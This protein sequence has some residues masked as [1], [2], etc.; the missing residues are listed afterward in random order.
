MVSLDIASWNTDSSK[1]D[2]NASAARFNAISLIGWNGK[3]NVGDDAMTAVMINYIL[4]NLQPQATFKLLA[5]DGC[6]A[7]YTANSGS[8]K[9]F[10][11]YNRF[12]QIPYLRRW[13]NPLLFDRRL[14]K[15]S[16]ILLVGG[17]SIFH[18]VFRSQRLAKVVAATQ[19]S[20][21]KTCIGALGV[22]LGPFKSD[23][24]TQ[25][26]KQVLRQ[27]DFIAV[28][29]QRSWEVFQSFKIETPAVRSMDIA[30]LLPELLPK[31]PAKIST[32]PT[33]GVALRQGHTPPEMMAALVSSLNE[34]QAA[35]GEVV[36]ELLN[37]SDVDE[38]SSAQLRSQLNATD[39]VRLYPYMDHPEEMYQR[40][41]ECDLVLASR[42]H[43]AVISYS[44]GTAFGVL[45]YHQKCVDFAQE[46]GL[47]EDWVMSVKTLSADKLSHQL[48]AAII[49]KNLPKVQ[50]PV[51][52]AKA[53]AR[54]SFQFLDALK[55]SR[56]QR[57]V[58]DVIDV[59][60]A[61]AAAEAV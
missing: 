52:T 10:A 34:L 3:R 4:Q 1:A 20:H 5:D 35:N 55:P 58:L 19:R 33:V 47:D 11:A 57:E 41:S 39:R 27:L 32:A 38:A 21:P 48:R 2:G 29:D 45:A 13:L 54:T 49:E 16:P 51:E 25:A 17:G 36:V 28:R 42:L 50:L 46:V 44:V 24:E 7:H 37:F 9:G 30:L 15:A 8:V 53:N 18:S 26:C 61:S 12:Q 14:A 56:S 60:E 23:A 31:F 6:L 22:S 40:L 43:A 59:P